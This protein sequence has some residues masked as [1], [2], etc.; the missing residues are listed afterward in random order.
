MNNIRK[1][2]AIASISCMLFSTA[3]VKAAPANSGETQ[4]STSSVE[5]SIEQY[6]SQIETV[7][8]DID[9]NKLEAAK[10]KSDMKTAQENIMNMEK[11]SAAVKETYNSRM[12]AMYM[13]GM[14]GYVNVLL[15]SENL[16]DFLTRLDNLK[17][18]MTHDNET[19]NTY[20]KQKE[21][22]TAKKEQL[23][24]EQN[25]VLAL[26]AENEKKLDKLKQDKLAQSKL[27]EDAKRQQKVFASAAKQP[28]RGSGFI[29]NNDGGSQQSGT[30]NV[31]SS[32]I[33]TA[34]VEYAKKFIGV[35]YLWGGTT[36]SGFDCSGFTQYVFAHFGRSIG[37]TTYEQINAGTAVSKGQ[38]QPGDL[39]LFGTV[40]NPHHVGI[41][42]GGN[43]YIHAPRTGEKIK[44]APMTRGDFVIGRR[45]K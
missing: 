34:V 12:R 19:I 20:M 28:S 7:M 38:L 23:D 30:E 24:M 39:V 11:D 13:N 35:P 1:L 10:L 33:G 16:S 17:I 40:S 8:R 37:R 42:V 21:E 4:N 3:P 45:I 15:G 5:V 14:G 2:V 6:D 31:E 32:Q 18:V 29:V 44:I 43:S 36:P 41:Y 9:K 27:I 22:L 25:K 26:K